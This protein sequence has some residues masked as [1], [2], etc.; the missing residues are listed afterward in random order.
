MNAQKSGQ[1]EK[2]KP[3][4]GALLIRTKEPDPEVARRKVENNIYF[5]TLYRVAL[6]ARGHMRNKILGRFRS[7]EGWY[8]R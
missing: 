7:G 2:R 8:D 4:S 5:A 1:K 3:A 6:P